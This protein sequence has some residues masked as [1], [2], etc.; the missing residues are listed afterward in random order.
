[1]VAVKHL[2]SSV[3]LVPSKPEGEVTKSH[4]KDCR[5]DEEEGESPDEDAN[6]KT[7]DA[8][9]TTWSASS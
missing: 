2:T 3:G 6:D 4:L 1:M 5:A 9:K 8:R 7:H